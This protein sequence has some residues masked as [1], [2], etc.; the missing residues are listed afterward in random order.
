MGYLENVKDLVT[1]KK[2]VGNAFEHE[3]NDILKEVGSKGSCERE[4]LEMNNAYF[5]HFEQFR[6][7]WRKGLSIFCKEF[8]LQFFERDCGKKIE[9]RSDD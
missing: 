1:G 5:R 7:D 9:F 8:G 6:S 3:L 4:F 2:T